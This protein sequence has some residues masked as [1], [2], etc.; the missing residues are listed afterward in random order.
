MDHL[1]QVS[2]KM[3][4]ALSDM[5]ISFHK[6]MRIAGYRP[7]TFKN[8]LRGFE[9][10]R[11]PGSMID[12]RSVFPQR[13][14]GA[15][16]FEECLGRR[17]IET[18]DGFRLTPGGEAMVRGKAKPRT[19]LAKA[20]AVLDEF[21]ARVHALNCD[22]NAVRYV[23]EVWLFG[24]VL[25]GVETVG[26]I[27]LALVTDRR[28]QYRIKGGY[29][30]MKAHLKKVMA[31][32]DDVPQA[33]GFLWSAEHWI[34]ERA[35]FGAKRHPLMAGVRTETDDLVALAVPCRLIY[36]R[37]QGGRIDAPILDRHPK[38]TSR[39]NDVDAP[40]VMPDLAPSEL[41]P[42]EARWVAGFMPWG[43]VSPYDIFRGW[44]D[45]AHK[46]FPNYPEGLLV[47]GDDFKPHNAP[48]LPKRLKRG[49]LDGCDAVALINAN[50]F[51]GTSVV[52]KRRIERSA[53][54]WTVVA[55]IEDLELFRVR[56][57]AASTVPD[58][59]AAAALILAVDVER[60]LR[61]SVETEERPA[62]QVGIRCEQTDHASTIRDAVLA[63]L[64]K[65]VI[66]IEPVG[67][68]G[69]PATVLRGCVDGC[70]IAQQTSAE[71][72]MGAPPRD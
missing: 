38:S 10:T 51:R 39:S 17:L 44:T 19:P 20:Q 9:R 32:R 60:M 46:L 36:D 58:L 53:T 30:Q 48:W 18:Q 35:L 1:Y 65:R 71:P 2:T 21:L 33:Q 12:L 42:M 27:D 56:R 57:L 64:E 16:V 62:V 52:L 7:A 13:R 23:D 55:S 22:E 43:G 4:R 50:E 41:R 37:S 25:Q 61:R 72:Q 40:M 70:Q 59:A 28:P 5:G 31:N 6:N 47:A 67:W 68:T 24:S 49:G 8:G 29:E 34:T 63:L 14:D 11:S 45:E 3:R 26:D 69:T 15:I 54:H 66:R